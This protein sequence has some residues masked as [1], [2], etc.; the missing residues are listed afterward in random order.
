[1][2]I[3]WKLLIGVRERQ[4]ASALEAVAR[5]R[6]TLEA[7]QA[8]AQALHGQRLQQVEAQAAHWQATL[9]ASSGGRLN[10]LHLRDAAAGSRALDVQI[11]RA[12]LA[13]S[14]ADAVVAQHQGQLDASRGE[15][16]SADGELMKARQMQE[17]LQAQQRQARERQQEDAAEEGASRTW[18]AKRID[19]LPLPLPLPLPRETAPKP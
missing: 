19:P 4:K 16:R 9:A 14:R 11:A 2:A 5:Q 13:A 17:R 1:M 7:S 6:R 10:A 3:D 12:G 15:L 18:L 8:Q